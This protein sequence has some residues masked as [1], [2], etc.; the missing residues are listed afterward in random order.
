MKKSVV[1][2][3]I[4]E[5]PRTDLQQTFNR[6]FKGNS[7]VTQQGLLDGLS[8]EEAERQLGVEDKSSGTLTSRF[9]SGEFVI[10][11]QEKVA[12]ALQKKITDLENKGTDIIVIL[13]TGSFDGLKVE[14]AQLVE[15]ETII[16][17]FVK[18]Q[19]TEGTIGVL[20][21]LKAQ[22]QESM[23]KWALGK[24][25]VFAAA[26]PY[27][28][29]EEIFQQA[30]KKLVESNAD[31]IILDCI[32]YNQ[33]MKEFAEKF[34]GDTAVIQSNAVLFQYVKQLIEENAIETETKA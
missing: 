28:F 4:G 29:T 33:N 21:P 23:E 9:V 7:R 10:M 13:C 20:V 6:Y 3:T 11:G 15:A 19:F 14:R 22:V 27:A 32:G 34:A 30:V 12:Q 17:P 26:S 25:G 16:V 1:F 5:A 31:V 2:L 8:K 18:E 24:R